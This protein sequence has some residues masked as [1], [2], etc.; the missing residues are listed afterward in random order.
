MRALACFH[1][2]AMMALPNGSALQSQRIGQAWTSEEVKELKSLARGNTPTG[3][4]SHKL[5]RPEGAIR[6]KAQR[7]RAIM[8]VNWLPRLRRLPVSAIR[9]CAALGLQ[10]S[11]ESRPGYLAMLG[12]KQTDQ[13]KS[14]TAALS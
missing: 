12:V 9:H 2:S 11:P 7:P 4:L 5:G 14:S 1:V 8:E 13:R 6:R 10:L 3:V